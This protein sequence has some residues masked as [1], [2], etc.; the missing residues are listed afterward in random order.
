VRF[1]SPHSART[2]HTFWPKATILY[3]E[4]GNTVGAIESVQDMTERRLMEQR[5]ERSRTELHVA[6]EIQRSFIP[7]KTPDIP[8]FE[9]AAVTIPAM[10]VG[11][12]FYDFISLP[13]AT[14][15]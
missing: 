6:A 10:E 15:D 13:M 11:G 4:I 2:A 7:K 9:V 12:D 8:N 5:L 14:T 3:D 1:S